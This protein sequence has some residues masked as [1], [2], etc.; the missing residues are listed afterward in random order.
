VGDGSWAMS[1]EPR[2]PECVTSERMGRR[3]QASVRY[4]TNCKLDQGLHCVE[5]DL[6]LFV[7]RTSCLDL[8]KLVSRIMDTLTSHQLVRV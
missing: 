3:G 7:A 5:V 2:Y 1:G 4:R 6:D 8:M